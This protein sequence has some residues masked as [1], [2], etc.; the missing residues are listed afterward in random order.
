MPISTDPA[1]PDNPYLP[2]T[3]MLAPPPASPSQESAH[4]WTPRAISTITFFLGF[5]SA[6]V[7]FVLNSK[8]LGLRD[9][10]PANVAIVGLAAF[11]LSGSSLFIPERFDRV[12]FFIINMC[13]LAYF[14]HRTIDD[15]EA[16][17]SSSPATPVVVRHWA[18]GLLW[19]LLGLAAFMLLGVVV[20]IVASFFDIGVQ[21]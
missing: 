5:P 11:A 15:L 3:T 19:S 17:N 8:A 10:I 20:V 18:K 6:F 2:P 21:G 4:V 9:R 14:R 7:L 1:S 12:L 13:F 16:F